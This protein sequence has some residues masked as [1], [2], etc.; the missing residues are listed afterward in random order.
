VAL[1]VNSLPFK[2]N[3]LASSPSIISK[4]SNMNGSLMLVAF[5]IIGGDADKFTLNDNKLTFKATTLKD[6]NDATYRINIK[7]TKVFDFGAFPSLRVV[8]LKVNL[9]SFK[10]NLSASPPIISN[11]ALPLLT[12]SVIT[13]L[14]FSG[15]KTLFVVIKKARNLSSSFSTPEN[16]NKVIMLA[17]NIKDP[18]MFDVFEIIDGE[19]ANKFTLKGNELTFK[20]TAR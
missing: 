11:V 6:G 1:K 3:L 2:V 15:V 14:V 10:V 5:D 17:T 12:A 7:A 13:L 4:T 20:A 9:L 19:D 16:T 8:A 18:F